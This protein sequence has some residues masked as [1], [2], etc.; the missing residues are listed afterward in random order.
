M[1]TILV[2]DDHRVY[3]RMSSYTLRKH[4]HTVLVASNGHEVWDIL[5]QQIVD[6]LLVSLQT[7]ETTE[8]TERAE[9]AGMDALRLVQALRADDRYQ[10]LPI[11]LLTTRPQDYEQIRAQSEPVNVCLVKPISSRE[12]VDTAHRLLGGRIVGGPV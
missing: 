2:A 9:T 1:A 8:T 11:I 6:L 3:Q 10:H 12:L 4:G 5:E 7:T